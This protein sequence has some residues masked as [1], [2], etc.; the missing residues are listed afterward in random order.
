MLEEPRAPGRLISLPWRGRPPPISFQRA[1]PRKALPRSVESAVA[2]AV[3]FAP[4]VLATQ[5]DRVAAEAAIGTARSRFFPKLNVELSSDHG[6][7]L[8]MAHDR[9]SDL[10]GLLVVRWNLFNGGVD[11]ARV[12]EAKA[13][14]FEAA[15]ISASTQ[16]V[17]EREVR[18]SWNAIQS[19]DQRVRFYTTQL[20]LN[21]QT[22]ATYGQQ[23]DVGQRRLLDLLIVQ[24]ETFVNEASLRT[25]ELV[26]SY[27]VFRVLAGM[28]RLV[29]ALGLEL[30][31]EAAM[32]PAPALLDHWRIETHSVRKP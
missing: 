32:P 26:A 7:S 19:A 31:P 22:R 13:R 29:T 27:N 14:S 4:S 18:V 2:D 8:D 24:N 30:P 23:F 1:P 21:R 10:S 12:L 16:R 17:V 3:A 11:Q 28:G 5:Q 25:E 9:Q 15:E 20:Q 6:K